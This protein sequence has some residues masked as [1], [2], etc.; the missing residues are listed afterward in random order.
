MAIKPW[1]HSQWNLTGDL[2]YLTVR[3]DAVS[4]RWSWDEDQWSP[5]MWYSSIRRCCL[6]QMIVRWTIC[7]HQ[8]YCRRHGVALF[9]LFAFHGTDVTLF[10]WQASHGIHSVIMRHHARGAWARLHVAPEDYTLGHPLTTN[11]RRGHA[12][13]YAAWYQP[14]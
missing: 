6:P 5:T 9:D 2:Y 13:T 14:W 12:C 10:L 1:L 11:A 7:I 8:W 3:C 4:V